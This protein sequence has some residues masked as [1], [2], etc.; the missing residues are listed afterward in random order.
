M[1]YW[2]PSGITALILV[3]VLTLVGS[4]AVGQDSKGF[5]TKYVMGGGESELLEEAEWFMGS[6]DFARALPIY[7]KLDV[8]YPG[9]PEYAFL[10]GTCYLNMPDKQENAIAYFEKA[11]KLKPDMRDIEFALGKAYFVNYRFD[12]AIDHFNRAVEGKVT[13]SVNLEEIPRLIEHCKNGIKIMEGYDE[14]WYKLTNLGASVNTEFDE[15]VPLV[16]FEESTMFYTYKG[17]RSTGG[18]RNLFGEP[19]PEGQ[20]FE[21]IFSC[22]RVADSWTGAAGVPGLLNSSWDD[23]A[24]AISPDGQK[25]FVYKIEKGGDIYVANLKRKNWVAPVQLEGE[26]NSKHWEG[27]A[28]MAVDG[29]TMYFSSDRPGGFGGKDLYKATLQSDDTWG[30][31]ENLGNKINTEFDDDAPFIHANGE[32]LYFSSKGHNSM[33]GYDIFFSKL[34]QK[35]W[36]KP[37]N[38]GHPVNTPNDDLHYVVTPSGKKAYFSSSRKGGQGGQ[39]LYEIEPGILGPKPSVTIVKGVLTY[40]GRNAEAL[41]NVTNTSTKESYGLHTSNAL[42]GKYL[43][44]LPKGSEYKLEISTRGRVAKTEIINLIDLADFVEVEANFELSSKRNS[45]IKK[46]DILQE[47]INSRVLEIAGMPV[48]E[49]AMIAPDPEPEPE[50][51]EEPVTA[52]EPGAESVTEPETVAEPEPIVESDPIAASEEEA[53]PEPTV[54]PDE[55]EGKVLK[56]DVEEGK[57]AIVSD[58]APQE[59]ETTDNVV[60]PKETSP[61]DTREAEELVGEPEP[62]STE[63]ESDPSTLRVTEPQPEETEAEPVADAVVVPE[64]VAEPTPVSEPELEVQP[65]TEIETI[66]EPE[67][68]P[69][70][71]PEPEP[72]SAALKRASKNVLFG[73]DKSFVS[74]AAKI[75]LDKLIAQMKTNSTLKAEINGHTDHIGPS[76]Y[77]EKLSLR[78]ANAVASYLK[79]KGISVARLIINAYGESRPIAANVHPDGSDNPNGRKKNRRTEVRLTESSMRGPAPQA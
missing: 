60:A 53:E 6:Q 64:P 16:S 48:E 72:E 37:T 67:P 24:M 43:I 9:I 58:R 44:A 17:K 41:I 11:Q 47:K 57:K 65:I 63:A 13:S 32:L 20:Y 74:N 22:K 4:V 40:N 5:E 26:I 38:I 73:F 2:T 79:S 12:E 54:A 8:R 62:E 55:E 45:D 71:E 15:Y 31:I 18:M 19:D 34:E 49:V 66:A 7:E 52:P 78:R 29:K 69:E 76:E 51:V 33:G 10:A 23:A 77:N 75:D 50:A 3:M 68:Q 1:K 25:L 59:S 56:T 28:S 35:S 27:H 14:R 70:P 36:Q 21:D 61:D 46:T 42:T 39:D 30:D